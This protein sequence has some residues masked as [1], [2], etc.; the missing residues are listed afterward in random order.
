MRKMHTRRNDEYGGPLVP[1][2]SRLAGECELS[3]CRSGSG[4]T[5]VLM[6][7]LA[8]HRAVSRHAVLVRDDWRLWERRFCDYSRQATCAE[9]SERL[10]YGRYLSI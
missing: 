5:G 1:A 8:S 9:G 10:K 4:K 7:N 6:L 2:L 3:S